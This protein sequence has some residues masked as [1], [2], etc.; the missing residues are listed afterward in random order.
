MTAAE[1]P[2]GEGRHL[3]F[4]FSATP[5]DDHAAEA[6]RSAQ[7]SPDLL[8]GSGVAAVQHFV[9]A[10][11]KPLPGTEP[12]DL[13]GVTVYE[14]PAGI[15]ELYRRLAA[16]GLAAPDGVAGS[17]KMLPLEAVKPGLLRAGLDEAPSWDDRH[18]VIAWSTHSGSDVDFEAWYDEVH[19]PHVV[20]MPGVMRSQRFETEPGTP[21]PAGAETIDLGHMQMDE[22]EGDA[23]PFREELKRQLMEGEMDIYDRITSFKTMILG[24]VSPNFAVAATA[25]AGVTE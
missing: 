7:R 11:T 23:G 10:D 14:G 21:P 13:G 8:A 24:A 15:G 12:L 9:P 18:L 19:I 6:W 4:L 1:V 17:L 2:S 5:A 16:G 3:L 25:D 22:L 20:N